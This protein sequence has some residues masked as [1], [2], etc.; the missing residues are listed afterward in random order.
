MTYEEIIEVL[1]NNYESIDHFA[2]DN[3]SGRIANK[4]AEITGEFKEVEQEG[5]EGEGDYWY[6]VKH[7]KHHN[8]YI[9]VEGSYSSYH[10]TDF[11]DGFN[12]CSN[13][14]PVEKI[15]TVYE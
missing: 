6:S 9:K 2:Y 13:V 4:V 8:I 15:V 11:Y 12:S 7:F 10:G 3:G 5:G 1:K 14:R